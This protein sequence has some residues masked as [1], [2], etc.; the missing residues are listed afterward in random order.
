MN[1]SALVFLVASLLLAGCLRAEEAPIEDLVALKQQVAAVEEIVT[2]FRGTPKADV[3][4]VYGKHTTIEGESQTQSQRYLYAITIEDAKVTDLMAVYYE[5]AGLVDRAGFVRRGEDQPRELQAFLRQKLTLLTAV[6]AFY[7]EKLERASWNQPD[8]PRQQLKALKDQVVA[9]TRI[10]EP[11]EGTLKAD[12]DAIY[13]KPHRVSVGNKFAPGYHAYRLSPIRMRDGDEPSGMT[14]FHIH[15]E[16]DLVTSVTLM[17]EWG[18]Q[19]H[20]LVRI[21]D[22]AECNREQSDYYRLRL[23]M[24][25]AV[26]DA[27]RE[28]LKEASWNQPDFPKRLVETLKERVAAQEKIVLPPEGTPKAEVEAVYGKHTE[29]VAARKNAHVYPLTLAAD[30]FVGTLELNI[31]YKNDAV[32][33]AWTKPKDEAQD[34]LDRAQESGRDPNALHWHRLRVLNAIQAAYREKLERASWNQ[35]PNSP[36][37]SR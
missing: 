16:N 17:R 22:P 26:H 25:A 15:Y 34:R 30:A 27:Y 32:L 21:L 4:V 2:P 6:H 3:E 11:P 29:V 33:H 20:G 10:V 31:L 18:G 37:D 1:R 36:A 14:E 7:R 12:V 19:V 35:P 8:A 5:P 13:G 23:R 28:K 9:L 24:L